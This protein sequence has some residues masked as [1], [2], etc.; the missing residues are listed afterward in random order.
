[1]GTAYQYPTDLHD[2]QQ[3]VL[4]PLLPK[5]K[6]RPGGPGHQL[7]EHRRVINGIFYC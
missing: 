7:Y 6:G 1:M 5:L 4:E 2:E 3:D